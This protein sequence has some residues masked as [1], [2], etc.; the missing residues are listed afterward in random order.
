MRS[1][2]KGGGIL[3][4]VP[5]LVSPRTS[6]CWLLRYLYQ[7]SKYLHSKYSRLSKR[8]N[9]IWFSYLCTTYLL[10]LGVYFLSVALLEFQ[11]HAFPFLLRWE[12]RLIEREAGT[13]LSTSAEEKQPSHTSHISDACYANHGPLSTA[14]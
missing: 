3:L 10:H 2:E 11:G 7:D 13:Q 4:R 8:W 1:Q 6:L 12:I 9:V 5:R 14:H